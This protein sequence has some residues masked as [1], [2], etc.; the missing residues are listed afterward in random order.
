[1]SFVDELTSIA[2]EVTSKHVPDKPKRRRPPG[3]VAAKPKAALGKRDPGVAKV[4]SLPKQKVAM[5]KGNPQK[6]KPK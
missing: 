1:M 4:R 5:K 6:M 3:V 2:K